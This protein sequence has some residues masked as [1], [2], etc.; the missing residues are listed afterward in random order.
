MATKKDAFLP[1][2]L[3]HLA[4]PDTKVFP[5]IWSGVIARVRVYDDTHGKRIFV[6]LSP[7]N[8]ANY[9]GYTNDANMIKVILQA[10]LHKQVLSGYSTDQYKILW[11]DYTRYLGPV[12]QNPPV[13]YP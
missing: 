3:Q 2:E 7:G 13:N 5:K 12:S 1:I 6:F 11:M 8:N 4:G 9:I 10:H